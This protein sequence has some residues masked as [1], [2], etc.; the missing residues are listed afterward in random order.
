MRNSL[1]L[2]SIN[3]IL[4][5]RVNIIK[6]MKKTRI[7]LE[8]KTSLTSKTCLVVIIFKHMHKKNASLNLV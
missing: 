7:V 5:N 8:Y 1:N 6:G 3:Q 2:K 4:L